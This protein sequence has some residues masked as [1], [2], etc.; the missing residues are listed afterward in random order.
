MSGAAGPTQRVAVVIG[1]P[2]HLDQ[3]IFHGA[4]E[5]LSRHLNLVLVAPADVDMSE[6]RDELAQVGSS[7]EVIRYRQDRRASRAADRLTRAM[8]FRFRNHSSGYRTTFM[9]AIVGYLGIPVAP[10]W[11]RYASMLRRTKP[12]TKA[13][14]RE[15][16]TILRGSRCLYGFYKRTA[17]R[18]VLASGDLDA[19]LCSTS[20][21]RLLVVMQ[22]QQAFVIQS[23]HWASSRRVPS[24]LIPLKWDNATSKS[25]I[26][27]RPTRL[28]VYNKQIAR[29]CAR[30]H[31]ISELAVVHVGSPERP[32]T[33][34]Q[35]D[36]ALRGGI[37]A[38]GSVA[39]CRL[40]ERWLTLLV[41]TI[42]HRRNV[43]QA[44]TP[45]IWRPYPTRQPEYLDFMHAFVKAHPEIV[46]DTSMSSQRSHR[47]A[48]VPI[49]E[50]RLAYRAFRASLA[51]AS[52]VVSETT[53][54]VIDARAHGVPVVIPAFRD[55]ATYGSQWHHL[56]GFEH[57]RWLWTTN[58]V[59]I[60]E[61]EEDFVRLVND[62][63]D[64]PRRIPPDNSGE[65][66]FVDERS[67]AQRLI[68]VIEDAVAARDRERAASAAGQTSGQG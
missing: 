27:D 22:R 67:Y 29:E 25:P 12:I 6:V 59:F 51:S 54:L 10:P 18:A 33:H 24:V 65:H 38:A 66:I 63:L 61:T 5:E 44:V 11:T 64:R 26:V 2:M 40:S 16:P 30:L 45:V 31:H 39:D 20:P 52:V 1:S 60:A 53:S 50:R 21:D 4:L 23:L 41:S 28:A 35:G 57:L 36:H 55:G 42:R 48:G 62:F 34:V 14:C 46:L 56:N 43:G 3:M 17:Y 32:E 47:H 68:D 7:V 19:V 15:A 13:L 49:G 37:L 9:N 58:G 8:T